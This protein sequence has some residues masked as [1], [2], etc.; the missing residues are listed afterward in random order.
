MSV[1]TLDFVMNFEDNQQSE[2]DKRLLVRFYTEPVHQEFASIQAGRPIYKDEDFVA[3]TTPGSRNT[4][5][6]PATYEYQQRFADQYKRFKNSQNQVIN[7]TPLSVLPWMSKS[8]VAE[9]AASNVHTVEALANMPDS[10][11]HMFMGHQQIKQRAQAYLDIAKDAAPML[12][13]QSE[14]EKRDAQIEEL[15]AQM[16]AV[17]ASKTETKAK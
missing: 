11:S 17:L 6:A 8:Q 14:L 5:T 15:Q 13:L 2:A 12:K 7:G 4:V 16:A 3:I 10:V 1:D 9:F